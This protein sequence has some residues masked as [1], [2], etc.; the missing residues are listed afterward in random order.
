M[1]E[2]C[3]SAVTHGVRRYRSESKYPIAATCVSTT[4]QLLSWTL[5]A[6]F[7]RSIVHIAGVLSRADIH[8]VATTFACAIHGFAGSSPARDAPSSQCLH[9]FTC[10]NVFTTDTCY[11]SN[12]PA[13]LFT[14][15]RL[16]RRWMLRGCVADAEQM[17][18]RL[19]SFALAPAPRPP[20][21][22]PPRT[23]CFRLA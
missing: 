14:R 19:S 3:S 15:I 5:L 22:A 13:R 9:W 10:Q 4:Y 18:L 12:Y 11:D 1:Q 8:A 2:L 7:P 21:P 6:V 23:A 20:R 16:L 17:S